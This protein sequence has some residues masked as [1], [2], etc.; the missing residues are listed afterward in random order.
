MFHIFD[1]DGSGTVSMQEFLDAVSKF[2]G[3]SMDNKIKF[4]FD[5][6]DLDSKIP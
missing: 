6:Y 3:Q 1:R 4:L 2:S 5:I